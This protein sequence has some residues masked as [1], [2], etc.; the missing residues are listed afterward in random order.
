[1][2]PLSKATKNICTLRKAGYR[3][4]RRDGFFEIDGHAFDLWLLNQDFGVLIA[5]VRRVID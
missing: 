4:I 2:Y 1:M 3:A 5:A